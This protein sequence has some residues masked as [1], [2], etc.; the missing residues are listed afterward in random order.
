MN[1]SVYCLQRQYR[2]KT[3]N[4]K[5][6]HIHGLCIFILI[7]AKVVSS[8][9]AHSE[10]Y[11]IQPYLI[12]LISVLIATTYDVISRQMSKSKDYS[13]KEEVKS[14]GN[15]VANVAYISDEKMNEGRSTI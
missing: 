8:N 12:K 7:F 1:S 4:T 13:L 14:T 15:G 9:P 10:V 5:P 3:N 6:G 2:Y 11:S